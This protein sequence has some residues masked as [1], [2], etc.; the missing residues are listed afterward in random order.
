MPRLSTMHSSS[1]GS[2]SVCLCL[3]VHQ[4][5]NVHVRVRMYKSEANFLGL[6]SPSTIMSQD[7]IQVTNLL[8]HLSG[9]ITYI[10]H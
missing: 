8:S 7:H 2:S 4:C 6:F 9:P 3:H 5:A 10:L 1:S